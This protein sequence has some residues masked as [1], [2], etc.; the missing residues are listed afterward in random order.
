MDCKIIRHTLL[1]IF[2]FVANACHGQ[3]KNKEEHSGQTDR[4]PAVAGTFYPADSFALRSSLKEAFSKAEPRKASG[5]VLAI[6]SPH[7]GYVYSAK[8]AASAFNQI[9]TAKKYEHIFVIGSSHHFQFYGASIYT[10]GDYITPLGH[11]KSDPLGKELV[12]NF[13]VFNNDVAPHKGEHT[14]EVQLPFLQY[15]MKDKLTVVPI[16]LGT[17]SPDVCEKL[18]EALKPYFN[19]KD[20]FV[21]STDFTHYPD[22]ET[23]KKVDAF[24]ADAVM[25]NSPEKLIS[26]VTDIENRNTPNLLTGMCGWTSVLTLLDISSTMPNITIKKVDY[27]NSGDTKY[28]DKSQVVGYVALEFESP[29]KPLSDSDLNLTDQE[30]H[31]LLTIARN[32][33]EQYVRHKKNPHID[34][35]EITPAL[36]TKCGAF[37]SLHLNGDL[38]GCIGTFRTDKAL[39][40]NVQEMA[41]A[42]A[43]SDYRFDPVGADELKSL[44]IEI[45]VLT[46]MRRISSIQEITLGKDG[47]YIKKD[48]RTGT[49]L[50]QVA[51][52]RNWTREEFLGYCSRDKA[53]LGWTGWKDAEIYTYEAIVFSEPHQK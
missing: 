43:T 15:L 27:Q 5:N 35:K 31:T 48:G 39:Y 10:I 53:G 24:M 42:A 50:P 8:V 18:A 45:S 16:I 14:I 13:K 23:A 40:Q 6:V 33:I 28:G 49:L 17:Q 30:K 52:D 1:I 2:L 29:K 41:V 44:D 4:Q 25:T 20:L 7:A 21:I 38:R 46:P 47:I 12:K 22:Y 36:K 26:A 3:M 32:S 19:E 9:D 11:V 51:T 37:V 34:T